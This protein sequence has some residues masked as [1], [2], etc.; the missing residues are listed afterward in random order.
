MM[1]S[2]VLQSEFSAVIVGIKTPEEAL[3]AAEKHLKFILG[4]EGA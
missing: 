1:I 2:Q 3:R 4:P